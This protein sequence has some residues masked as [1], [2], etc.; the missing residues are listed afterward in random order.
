MDF[1]VLIPT[2]QMSELHLQILTGHAPAA[3][4][5][6]VKYVQ[7]W[8][9]EPPQV[10]TTEIKKLPI[11]ICLTNGIGLGVFFNNEKDSIQSKC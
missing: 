10:K 5:E 9:D 6:D 11:E 1:S 2:W 4:C 8:D 3:G 7:F